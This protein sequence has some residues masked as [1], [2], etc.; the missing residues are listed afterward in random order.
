[1]K[2]P[3]EIKQRINK[4]RSKRGKKNGVVKYLWDWPEAERKL[5]TN[6]HLRD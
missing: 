2:A 4:I 3:K 6:K 1:M 5:A